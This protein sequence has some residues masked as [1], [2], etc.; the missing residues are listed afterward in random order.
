MNFAAVL[1]FAFAA[2]AAAQDKVAVP[3]SDPSQ[4]ATVKARLIQGSITVTVGSGSQVVVQSEPASS[5]REPLP[6]TPPPP[7]G[8][9][10]IDAGG[11]G[12]NAEEDHNV[13][14]IGGGLNRTNLTIEVPANSSLELRTVNGGQ[15]NV[16][17]VNGNIDVENVNGSVE[18]K[19]VSG[20]VLAHTVNGNVTVG[21][22]RPT[23]DKPM[24]FSS[25]NGKV[26]VTLPADTKARLRL[27][28]TNGAIFS[29][30]DV[31][32]EADNTKPVIEDSRGQGGRYRIRIDRGSNI[33]GTINGGGPEYSFQTMNGTILIHRK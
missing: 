24:S 33:L 6:P 19:D 2:T 26:D 21:L 16:T 20:T 11:R 18:L 25:L 7:P 30:F 5:G 8:M 12:F 1:V 14:T 15:I 29:D 31:K 17:G 4:P 10:R 3:L 13:V 28:T 32:L 23:P 27:K 22:T 9:H